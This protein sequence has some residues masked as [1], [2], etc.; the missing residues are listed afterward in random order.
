MWTALTLLACAGA[1]PVAPAADPEADPAADPAAEAP[2]LPLYEQLYAGEYGTETESLGARVRILVWLREM[3]FSPGQLVDLKAASVDVRAEAA[4]A[5]TEQ[6]AVDA[7]EMAALGPAYRDLAGV[8]VQ[9]DAPP[10]AGDFTASTEALASARATLPDHGTARWKR[11]RSVL[12]RAAAFAQTLSAEQRLSMRHAL[13]FLRKPLSPQFAPAYADALFGTRWEDGDFG[14][15]ARFDQGPE[16][17]GSLDVGGLWR[18]DGVDVTAEIKGLRL[19]T[20]IAVALAHDGLCGAIEALQGL[21]APADV[22]T[23]CVP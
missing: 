20:L 14:T 11:I 21:R 22:A 4:A 23:A 19:Q 18:V 2:A 10:S 15:I 5:L 17:P 7:A 12:N 16:E 6:R 1:L 13:F 9:G 3:A 8:L